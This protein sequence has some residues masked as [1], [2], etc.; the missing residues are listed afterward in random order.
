MTHPCYPINFDLF[1]WEWSKKIQNGHLKKTEFFKIANSQYLTDCGPWINRI[2][3]CEGHWCGSTYMVIYQSY[4]SKDQSQKFS[5]KKY[6]ELVFSQKKTPRRFIWGS[7]YFCTMDGF[8]RIL[9]KAVSEL[10][11]TRLYIV[12]AATCWRNKLGLTWCD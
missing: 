1:S 8:F 6:W 5:R 7:V 2:D 9:K 12:A 11:C 4:T 3:W 10:I